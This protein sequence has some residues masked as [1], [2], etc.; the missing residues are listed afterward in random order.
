MLV[1]CTEVLAFFGQCSGLFWA[2][3]ENPA[4][5]KIGHNRWPEG[6]S[7][8]ATPF[9]NKE[10]KEEAVLMLLDGHLAISVAER[11]RQSMPMTRAT[12]SK[13]S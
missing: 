13:S 6:G 5:V 11:L 2:V 1:G 8:E 7:A 9:H 3:Q 12:I 4:H 10:F